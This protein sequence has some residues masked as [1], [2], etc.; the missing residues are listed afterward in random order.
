M[1]SSI[2]IA[3]PQIG[4]YYSMNAI[5]LGWVA[6]SYLLAAAVFLVPFGK[7]AD[8]A[9][10]KKI[11][12]IGIIIYTISSLLCAISFSSVSLIVFRVI[13]GIGSAMIFS[14]GMAIL[15][16]VY[17]PKERGKAFGISVAATYLGLSLGP[18][19]G[20]FMTQQLGWRSIFWLNVPVGAFLV[21]L[22]LTL[23]KGEW[24]EAK[25][26]KFDFLGAAVLSISLVALMLGMSQL[27]SINGVILMFSGTLFMVAFL[28]IQKK[29]LSPL[30]DI[31]LFL[32]NRVFAFSNLAA[33]INYS[34][35]FAVTFLLS[36]YLQ[37][38][39]GFS[40][41]YAGTILIAQPIIMSVFSPF[42]GRL[43]DKAEP[44]LVASA[45][46][47][48]V[49]AGLFL[50]VFVHSGTSIITIIGYLMI[51]GLGFA[52]FSSPNTNAV[53]S[54]VDKKSY[55]IASSLLGTMR[56]TG[57]MFSMGIAMF[58]FSLFMGKMKIEPEIYPLF[59]KSMKLIFM[60]FSVLCL[61]GIFAS[62]SRGK[63]R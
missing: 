11:Y 13:Q 52:L 5:M 55:G 40:A 54:S 33:F 22:V 26:E 58:V 44:R 3:L 45:G 30:I 10:R 16:S 9:G 63:V 37:Y 61:T 34:A 57:Q 48:L 24:A 28:F 27:P 23:L 31:R 47:A 42:A 60:I 62:M 17:P 12:T 2:N 29:S 49:T 14:T 50:L 41:Q 8:I 35:T 20:G 38:I 4:E 6:T 32:H 59:M 1:G 56:L 7:L 43:S 46:M 19:L 51:L 25:G 15:T 36:L 21:F 53:M 39:K 18:F